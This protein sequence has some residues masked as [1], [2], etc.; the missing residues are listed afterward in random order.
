MSNDDEL[1]D[2]ARKAAGLDRLS[3]HTDKILTQSVEE[4][5]LSE[6]EKLKARYSFVLGKLDVSDD[7]KWTEKR[8][9]LE[10]QLLDH[11]IKPSTLI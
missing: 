11:D 1:Y 5:G 8:K 2:R 6:T 4:G 9:D 10:E 7:P 3:D